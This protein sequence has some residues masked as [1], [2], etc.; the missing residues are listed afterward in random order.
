M[1]V[2]PRGG[3][4]T[5]HTHAFREHDRLMFCTNRMRG[6]TSRHEAARFKLNH[7]F[8]HTFSKCWGFFS[9][10]LYLYQLCFHSLATVLPLKSMQ[11]PACYYLY[12]ALC[13]G[14]DAA[15]LL[16]M[17]LQCCSLL[18]FCKMP[19]KQ[20]CANHVPCSHVSQLQLPTR[21]LLNREN[22]V[23]RP[24]WFWVRRAA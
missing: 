12:S 14:R 10:S 7:L 20:V 24:G 4:S 21:Q 22:A 2:S 11:E 5:E 18:S 17:D 23:Q 15:L 19:L 13:C 8:I 16:L 6:G 1:R 3:R 9:P